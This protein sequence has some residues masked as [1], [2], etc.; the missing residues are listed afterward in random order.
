MNYIQ[1]ENILW[2]KDIEKLYASIMEPEWTL[3]QN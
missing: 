2:F 1:E 3:F